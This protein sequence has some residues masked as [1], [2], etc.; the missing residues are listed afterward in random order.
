MGQERFKKG[1]L[2]TGYIAEEFPEG[3]AGVELEEQE[4]NRLAAF[5][6]C[7]AV[8]RDNF[9]AG[10]MSQT[11]C[12]QTVMMGDKRWDFD[13]E[14]RDDY[15]SICLSGAQSK[16]GLVWQPGETIARVRVDDV[17][18]V[19]KVKTVT[20]G[21]AIRYRG[22]DF[23]MKVMAPRVADL[24]V[25]MPVKIPPDMSK[26]LLCPMPGVV[27]GLD[28]G[29]GDMVEDGQALAVVEAMKM[30][31]VLRATKR[32][33]VSKIHADVGS[34]LAVDEVILEFEEA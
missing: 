12:S 27:V 28:V 34:I 21:F 4:L 5:A 6:A 3:F 13:V 33:R 19:L 1:Q 8:R 26:F 11:I 30:E 14:T 20:G 2:T 24:M 7:A 22:T 15:F 25:L 16:V 29:E 10:N 9:R 31:N 23:T 32:A 17:M 18:R